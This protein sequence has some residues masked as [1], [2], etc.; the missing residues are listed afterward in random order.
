MMIVTRNQ[1]TSSRGTF[2][3]SDSARRNPADE[4]IT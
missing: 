4:A 3:D 1:G 2:S